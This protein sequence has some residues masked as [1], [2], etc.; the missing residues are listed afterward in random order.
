MATRSPRSK[1]PDDKKIQKFFFS[2]ERGRGAKGDDDWRPVLMKR[3]RDLIRD[4]CDYLTGR[5]LAWSTIMSYAQDIAM[6]SRFVAHRPGQRDLTN[7]TRADVESWL[8]E[9]VKQGL[10]A[11]T[12]HRRHMS[13]RA[14][15]LYLV[16]Q[17]WR[18]DLRVPKHAPAV[19]LQ[20]IRTIDIVDIV[21]VCVMLRDQAQRAQ[22]RRKGGRA[23]FIEV[24]AKR[25]AAIILLALSCGLR[26]DE[27]ARLTLD[28]Y[29]PDAKTLRI[30]F[31]KGGKER[32]Q[33]VP[34]DITLLDKKLAS[35]LDA[36]NAWRRVRDDLP[37]AGESDALWIGRKGPL[38]TN[39]IRLIMKRRCNKAGVAVFTPHR[40]RH[41]WAHWC[42]VHGMQDG[43][44]KTLGGWSSDS[45]VHRYGRSHA[46]SRAVDVQ[47]N[48]FSGRD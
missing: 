9:C 2:L 19:E 46:Q 24:D 8:A 43:D 26:V 5:R 14:F 41:T 17:G 30:R 22:K 33:V 47:R 48:L 13:A 16:D 7:A 44:L 15:D 18:N 37:L 3:D 4:W 36:L 27:L 45:M 20:D 12:H 28:D 11:S 35:P 1:M 31:G 23:N 34:A 25:D 40:F 38:T 42:K 39:G 21:T 6:L 10:S 32:V 29:D